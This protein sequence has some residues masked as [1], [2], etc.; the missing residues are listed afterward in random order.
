V[1]LGERHLSAAPFTARWQAR[2]GKADL[3]TFRADFIDF[4]R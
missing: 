1:P 4:L 2:L 3:S